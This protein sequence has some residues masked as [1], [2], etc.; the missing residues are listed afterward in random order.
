M[1][2]ERP[3]TVIRFT[4]V[5]FS[6]SLLYISTVHAAIIV[7][8][9]RFVAEQRLASGPITFPLAIDSDSA[10]Y[11]VTGTS[12]FDQLIR[13]DTDNSVTALSSVGYV[14]GVIADL[15]IGFGGDLFANY[16]Q[17]PFG[18]SGTHGVLRFNKLTGATS[19]FYSASSFNGD[20]GLAYSAVNSV[21]YEQSQLPD[22][23]LRAIDSFGHATTLI[24]SLGEG[25][26]LALESAG[27]LVSIGGTNI[28]RI[29]LTT[30]A[31]SS[32]FDITSSLPGGAIPFRAEC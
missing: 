19:V 23:P 14:V 32:I 12:V 31:V 3:F 21:L 29:D 2:N 22:A 16:T 6:V 11:S 28:R 17:L 18:S 5:F 7:H 10:I 24:A 25:R 27:S 9:S 13:I 8:D 20:G 15:E 30:L 4:I 26:G 1:S